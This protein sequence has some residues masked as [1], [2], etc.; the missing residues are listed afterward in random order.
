MTLVSRDEVRRIL[1]R[2][3]SDE[4]SEQ[5]V[6]DWANDRWAVEEVLPEDDVVAEILSSLDILDINQITKDDVPAFIEALAILD[7]EEALG[8]LDAY[9]RTIDFDRRTQDLRRVPF[10]ARVLG[11]DT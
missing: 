3:K 4:L 10:Y 5:Q 9:F 2:W 7:V 1:L 11:G 8:R 6:Y